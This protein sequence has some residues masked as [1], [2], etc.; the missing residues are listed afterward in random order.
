MDSRILQSLIQINSDNISRVQ[1]FYQ[2]FKDISKNAFHAGKDEEH[3]KYLKLAKKELAKMH[4]LERNQKIL[5]Q[6]LDDKYYN[7]LMDKLTDDYDLLEMS[8]D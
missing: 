3:K 1:S 7:E 5:K 4:L 2:S 6:T 8:Y